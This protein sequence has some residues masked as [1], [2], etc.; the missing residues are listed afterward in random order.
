[1]NNQRG[2]VIVGLVFVVGALMASL[3]A[4]MSL[5]I[6]L[7][8]TP[9]K[10]KHIYVQDIAQKL[11]SRYEINLAQ[12]NSSSGPIDA[13]APSPSGLV[14]ITN[15]VFGA[16]GLLGV[17]TPQKFDTQVF[18]SKIIVRGGQQLSVGYHTF[19]VVASTGN[20]N[21]PLSFSV[22]GNGNPVVVTDPAHT[23]ETQG[24]FRRY[25]AFTTESLV[26]SKVE[27]TL[28]KMRSL[29][30]ILESFY[31]ARIESDPSHDE[32][33]NYFRYEQ[34]EKTS[35]INHVRATDSAST[36]PYV[37][38]SER[39]LGYD[40]NLAPSNLA[41]GGFLPLAGSTQLPANDMRSVRL[42][43]ESVEPKSAAF[44][45]SPWNTPILFTNNPDVIDRWYAAVPGHRAVFRVILPWDVTVN[46]TPERATLDVTSINR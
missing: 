33:V 31:K 35:C 18:A 29:S 11:K 14:N 32:S 37:P 46:G 34:R 42:V 27:F 1:M 41:S 38:C 2:S 26:R 20:G 6:R 17:S 3:V 7:K 40:T 36:Y 13:V 25:A 44:Y 8:E 21:E 5:S 12:V 10:E 16:N 39:E 24:D 45:T 15:L 19:F 30:G 9:I 23:Y 22:D 4:Y 28:E 43:L